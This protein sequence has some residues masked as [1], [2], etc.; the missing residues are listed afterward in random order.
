MNWKSF[1]NF[2]KMVTPLILKALFWLGVGASV[3]SGL[4][5]LFS[6]L[7]SAFNRGGFGAALGGLIGGPLVII[8]GILSTRIY[9]ELLILAFQINDS[10]TDIKHLLEKER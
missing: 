6:G 3:L 4:A 7:A 5:V 2:E 10:L 9:T 1:L 8:L